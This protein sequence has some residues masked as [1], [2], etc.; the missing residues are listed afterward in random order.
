MA[1]LALVT[2]QDGQYE[3]TVIHR[4]LRYLDAPGDDPLGHHDRVVGLMGGTSS[5]T[6]TDCG[7]VK[8]RVPLS[9]HSCASSHCH[10]DDSAPSHVGRYRPSP[11]TLRQSRPLDRSCSPPTY[12]AGARALRRL[13]S[14]STTCL[15]KAG[16]S[17]NCRRDHGTARDGDVPR[18][19][20][21]VESSMYSTGRRGRGQTAVPSVHHPFTPLGM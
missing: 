1:F 18:R 13:A 16:L 20:H 15:V 5:R 19:H 14:A 8:H 17:K 7:G 21:V 2:G 6:N 3:V 12:T 10:R 9:G 4:M 11:R